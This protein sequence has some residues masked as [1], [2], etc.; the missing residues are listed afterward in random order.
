MPQCKILKTKITH[1]LCKREVHVASQCLDEA[2][3]CRDFKRIVNILTD[4]RNQN[5][6]ANHDYNYMAQALQQFLEYYK[7]SVC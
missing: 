3:A 1:Q 4:E 6:I 2:W 5:L 7:A